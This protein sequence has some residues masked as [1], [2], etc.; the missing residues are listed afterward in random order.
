MT[1]GNCT[2]MLRGMKHQMM[3]HRKNKQYS[4]FAA[5]R[6]REKDRPYQMQKERIKWINL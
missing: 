5:A 6:K 4:P 2:G 3:Q 1:A